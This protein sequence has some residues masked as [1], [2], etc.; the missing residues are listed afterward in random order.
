MVFYT[1]FTV[2]GFSPFTFPQSLIQLIV[3]G[4]LYICLGITGY[5]FQIIS[6]D[7]ICL[8]NF[9]SAVPDKMPS[10]LPKRTHLTSSLKQSIA[11]QTDRQSFR[12]GTI[13]V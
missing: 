5:N 13:K 8:C 11:K 10:S 1:G 12:D 6:E 3:D 9:Y 4:P 2:L 7:Q